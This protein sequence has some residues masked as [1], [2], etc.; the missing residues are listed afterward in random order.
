MCIPA[1]CAAFRECHVTMH[2]RDAVGCRLSAIRAHAADIWQSLASSSTHSRHRSHFVLRLRG[3]ADMPPQGGQRDDR[4]MQAP[5]MPCGD[6]GVVN[7]SENDNR[8]DMSAYVR[9]PYSPEPQPNP[10]GD[11][12]TTL[13]DVSSDPLYTEEQQRELRQRLKEADA[14]YRVPD[15]ALYACTTYPILERVLH[16]SEYRPFWRAGIVNK[17]L[18]AAA[19]EGHDEEIAFVVKYLEANVNAVDLNMHN[20]TALM[21]AAMNGHSLTVELL[22]RL[23]ADVNA[24]DEDGATALHF[25]ADRGWP[26]VVA[27]LAR[28]G[29]DTWRRNCWRRT[30]LD[31]LASTKVQTLTQL[32]VQKHKY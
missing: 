25:A 24:S 5:S 22:V 28:L 13:S 19:E 6:L 15:T 31:W 7:A 27:A 10:L 12:S 20:Y 30:A 14:R 18:W 32:Q 2:S 29:A 11:S 8:V 4:S 21:R 26:K 3:G 23:G 1:A 9:S 17:R 16:K